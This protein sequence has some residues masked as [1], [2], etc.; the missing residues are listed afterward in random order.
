MSSTISGV[1]LCNQIIIE[2]RFPKKVGEP[3]QKA[4]KVIAR[5]SNPDPTPKVKTLFDKFKEWCSDWTKWG[6]M[7]RMTPEIHEY[8]MRDAVMGALFSGPSF[9]SMAVAKNQ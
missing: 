8:I 6:P 7:S 3:K 2:R 4:D 9:E 5:Q 1:F